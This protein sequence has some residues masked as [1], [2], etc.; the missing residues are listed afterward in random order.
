MSQCFEMS[1]SGGSASME[2]SE[3][4][5]QNTHQVVQHPHEGFKF[6]LS[7]PALLH[8]PKGAARPLH[9]AHLVRPVL[10]LLQEDE[11]LSAPSAGQ[12]RH[13][14]RIRTHGCVE[15]LKWLWCAPE[16]SGVTEN[17]GSGKAGELEEDI[18]TLVEHRSSDSSSGSVPREPREGEITGVK[19]QE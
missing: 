15:S 18:W 16:G 2:W 5:H 7:Q 9:R 10:L 1:G 11:V 17:S 3:G 12:S 8:G 14:Q 19:T 13:L 6:V 4:Q